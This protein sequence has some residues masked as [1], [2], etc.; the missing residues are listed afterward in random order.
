MIALYEDRI[1][2]IYGPCLAPTYAL[3]KCLL[4][5]CTLDN[6]LPFRANPA[7]YGERFIPTRAGS[8][9]LPHNI[10]SFTTSLVQLDNK[11]C[12]ESCTPKGGYNF[13][14]SQLEKFHNFSQL[15][16]TSQLQDIMLLSWSIT[17]FTAESLIRS[18]SANE[19]RPLA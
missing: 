10:M 14:T 12:C 16:T 11:L 6:H 15:F 18:Y 4:E 19:P 2:Q 5:H 8:I 1:S 7:M 13:T 9:D 3:G 17:D